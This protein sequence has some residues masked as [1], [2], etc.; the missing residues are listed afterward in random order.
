MKGEDKGDLSV[1][2]QRSFLVIDPSTNGIFD[3]D[4]TYEGFRHR[5]NIR[6][7]LSVNFSANV[8]HTVNRFKRLHLKLQDAA[9]QTRDVTSR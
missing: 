5:H 6:G 2:L 3:V 7:I 8:S 9:V 4:T 1:A